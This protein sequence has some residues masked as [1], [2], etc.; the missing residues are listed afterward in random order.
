MTKP[1]TVESTLEI[2]DLVRRQ[3]RV[4]YR[5]G[6]HF[7][8][9]NWSR[10]GQSLLFNGGGRLYSIPITGGTPALLDSGFAVR[11]NNDHG[12]SP[13]GSHIVISDETLGSSTIY[14]LPACGGPPRQVT[15]LSPSYW[16]GWSPDGKTLAYCAERNGQYDIYSIS[17]DGGTETRLTTAPG[18]DDGPDYSPDGRHIYFNSDRTGTMHLYRM[19]ADGSEQTQLTFDDAYGDWFAHPSPD[20]RHIVFLSYASSVKGHPPNQ[21]V[22]L[23]LMNPESLEPEVL[24]ELFGGQGTLN[25]PSWSPDSLAFAFVSYALV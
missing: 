20:G 7:E 21:Q 25:V 24:V 15:A 22:A 16:H 19:L 3:R 9:P 13:D 2:F 10:D 23:R 14:V 12:Y 4:V 18:L 1:T 17:V 6:E 8:A 5:A 11:C